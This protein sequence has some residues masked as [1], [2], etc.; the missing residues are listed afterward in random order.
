MFPSWGNTYHTFSSP[1]LPNKQKDGKMANFGAKPD[2]L[3]S[4]KKSQF[5]EFLYFLFF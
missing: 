1:I 4:L 5:V 3:T 2:G